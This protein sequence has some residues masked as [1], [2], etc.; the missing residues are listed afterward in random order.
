MTTSPAGWATTSIPAPQPLEAGGDLIWQTGAKLGEGPTW[1]EETASLLMVDIFAGQVHRLRPDARSVDTLTV[2]QP[3]SSVFPTASGGLALTGKD[4]L[5]AVSSDG[6]TVT[7][8]VRF[9][10]VGEK[11]RMNDAKCDPEGRLFAGSMTEIGTDSSLYRVGADLDVEDV[12]EGVGISNGLAWSSDRKWMYYIDSVSGSVDRF[13]YDSASGEIADRS[14]VVRIDPGLGAPD[15]MCIDA[16]DHLWVAI[17]GGG[18]V[19]RY[20]PSGLIADEIEVPAPNVTSCCFGGAGYTDLYVTTAR[21]GLAEEER[22]R[23]PLSGSV[24]RFTP[25]VGGTAPFSFAGSI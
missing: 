11:E 22:E 10:D 14:V 3:V 9:P 25:A 13:S 16:E 1:D 20:D 15:G 19:R 18:I 2:G 8:L 12:L 23:F 17:F 6:V 7:E 5:V 21:A 24:F 4:S